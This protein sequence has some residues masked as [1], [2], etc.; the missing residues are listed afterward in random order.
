MNLLGSLKWLVGF[1][2]LATISCKPK[3]NIGIP[4][5][6]QDN[7]GAFFD[8]L[9][10]ETST[11]WND[12]VG[13]TFSLDTPFLMSGEYQDKYFG[14][15]TA[16]SYTSLFM[17]APSN[18][19]TL[20]VLD[21]V[22]M[23]VWPYAT[24]DSVIKQDLQQIE[25]YEIAATHQWNYEKYYIFS[26]ALNL[27]NK[28]LANSNFKFKYNPFQTN[29]AYFDKVSPNT[30][31][32]NARRLYNRYTARLDDNF[33]NK[34]L[35]LMQLSNADLQKLFPGIAIKGTGNKMFTYR[36]LTSDTSN[37]ITL[38]YKDITGRSGTQK[39]VF[40][41]DSTAYYTIKADW[42]GTHLAMLGGNRKEISSKETNN[43]TFIQT[44]VGLYTK[45][46]LLNIVELAKNRNILI[47]KAELIL[48]SADADESGFRNVFRPYISV[49][50]INSEK[51]NSITNIQPLQV[52]RNSNT[53][54]QTLFYAAYN[55]STNNYTLDITNY[56]QRLASKPNNNSALL[57]GGN[58][59]VN[60]VNNP[61]Y[62]NQ[63]ID[64]AVLYDN[65]YQ[66]NVP[67]SKRMKV[68]ISYTLVD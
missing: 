7:I 32:T 14:Q 31:A 62:T 58:R 55:Y 2:L 30:A 18:F 46:K 39:F 16:V 1:I 49:F 35:S 60:R 33:G 52:V 5:E 27:E 24:Q 9:S 20:P 22:V 42:S 63:V 53:S 65:S 26:Q 11:V 44:G 57:I 23:S 6:P 41:S 3:Y 61:P 4:K 21:S 15:I 37:C 10:L 48:S 45:V 40:G 8:T 51:S 12:S 54:S 34:L 56:V 28:D 17:P 47:N 59:A 68:N 43:L 38:F 64:R 29:K 50:E 66:P 36:N 67:N 25:I 13:T 19:A